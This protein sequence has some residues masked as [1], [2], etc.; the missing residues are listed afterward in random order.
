MAIADKIEAGIKESAKLGE[1]QLLVELGQ[2]LDSIEIEWNSSE[3]LT[4]ATPSTG[5]V[6]DTSKLAGPA[7][8]RFAAAA[9]R[10]LNR[11]NESLYNMICNPDDPDNPKL[12]VAAG[13]GVEKLGL[14]LAGVLAAHFAWL[15]AIIV[16]V[17]ALVLKRFSKDTYEVACAIWKEQL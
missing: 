8:D 5:P 15:P 4:A 6:L 10:F 16:V 7:A 2:H 1:D 12:R 11:Y 17:V 13:E 3:H 14:V 9:K